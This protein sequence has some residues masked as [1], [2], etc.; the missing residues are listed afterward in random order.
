MLLIGH[1]SANNAQAA[2]GAHAVRLEASDRFAGVAVGFLKGK[3]SVED[4]LE[5][6]PDGRTL[7]LPLA[8]SDGHVVRVLVPKALA[9]FRQP[10]RMLQVLAPAGAASSLPAVVADFAKDAAGRAALDP[11]GAA[12]LLVAHG[13][14]TGESREAAWRLAAALD[15]ATP[16]HTVAT[17]FVEE[18]PSIVD[19]VRRIG[20]PLVAVGLFAERGDHVLRD[21]SAP[22]ADLRSSFGAPIVD[23]GP[24][25]AS[26]HYYRAI[27]EILNSA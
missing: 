4:A 7:V 15:G 25:G 3:P 1:G 11:T 8:L 10:K 12:L 21:I 18:S 22:L 2:A 16:F 13:G 27:E 5:C 6:L 17:A 20:P 26:P 24:I 19:T 9:K 14:G 23:A